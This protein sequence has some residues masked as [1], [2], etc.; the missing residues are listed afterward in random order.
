MR[1]VLWWLDVASFRIAGAYRAAAIIESGVTV[2][3]ARGETI[4]YAFIAFSIACFSDPPWRSIS[5]RMSASCRATATFIALWCC[6]QRFVDPS[7]SVK[8]N[9]TSPVG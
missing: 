3:S 9:A 7:T 2:S 6:S 4:C 1:G 8:R 5:S